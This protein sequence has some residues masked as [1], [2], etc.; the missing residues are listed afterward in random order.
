MRI[1]RIFFA[2]PTVLYIR[3]LNHWNS[4]FMHKTLYL[5]YSR[6]HNNKFCSLGCSVKSWNMIFM[7]ILFFQ[8]AVRKGERKPEE[9]LSRKRDK[10]VFFVSREFSTEGLW[11]FQAGWITSSSILKSLGYLN[12]N[13]TSKIVLF[14]HMKT[15]HW[16]SGQKK[17]KIF[18]RSFWE[19]ASK[20]VKKNDNKEKLNIIM[21]H[22]SLFSGFII[23]LSLEKYFPSS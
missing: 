10:R 14:P 22:K 1:S 4:F 7:K 19:N 20:R 18:L 6:S 9:R 11:T 13:V 21:V 15:F 8:A 3:T 2:R 17:I 16:T 5:Q 12:F 23:L